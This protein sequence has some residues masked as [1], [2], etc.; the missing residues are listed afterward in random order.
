MTALQ[1]APPPPPTSRPPQAPDRSRPVRLALLLA[2]IALVWVLTGPSVM[3]MIGALVVIIT[4]HELGHYLTAKWSGMK[5]TEF[6][7]GFGPRIW[8]FRRGETEYGLK[9][10]PAGAYV[11][12]IGLNNLEEIDP[13]DEARTYRQQSYPKRMLV[14]LA[15]SG[16]HFVICL[17][18]I[19]TLLVGWGAPGGRLFASADDVDPS[20]WEV[21]TVAD[22]SAADLAG[23]RPGDR[24]LSVDGEPVV[25]FADLG[26]VVSALAG[27]PVEVV[28]ERGGEELA[29]H[30]TIQAREDGSGLL[31][32]TGTLPRERSNPIEAVPATLADF[33]RIMTESVKATA[34]LLSP[35]G[36]SSFAGQVADGNGDDG[37]RAAAPATSEEE[38]SRPMS[39]VGATRFGAQALESGVDNF[40]YVLIV[41]NA[42]IGLFNLIPLLPLDGGHAAIGTYERIREG[43]SG[44]RYFVDVTRLLPL[45]YAVVMGLVILGVSA[46]YLDVV[47][48]PNIP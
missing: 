26:S 36:I 6:F 13:A 32:V 27:E 15:G 1:P 28:V 39:V 25:T 31:G 34:Q 5:V 21:G 10:I 17:A 33:G 18:L 44:K 7:L 24:V 38:A 20:T 41:L 4:L 22:D 45:T 19:F 3:V 14:I 23:V 11:K 37:D 16:M 12:I 35:S 46:A 29:I 8:S 30:T 43:R 2:L 42:F 47:N 40:L 48:P 9:A